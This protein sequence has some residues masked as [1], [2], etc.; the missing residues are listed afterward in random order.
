MS[1]EWDDIED[2][3]PVPALRTEVAEVGDPVER[4]KR[5]DKAWNALTIV[6]KTFLH[7]WQNSRFN[8]Q[9]AISKLGKSRDYRSVICRWRRDNEDFAFCEKVMK[10]DATAEVLERE[11]LTLRQDEIAEA[12]LAKVPILHQGIDTGFREYADLGVALRANETLLRQGGH[13]KDEQPA[14]AFTGP[15]LV[16]QLTTKIGEVVQ[17]TKIGVAPVVPVPEENWDA[18]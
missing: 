6:Q 17:E 1:G 5:F 11:R 2:H 3:V 12:G 16:V 13:L 8:A 15:A 18:I 14:A 4:M 9:K 10:S 7:T